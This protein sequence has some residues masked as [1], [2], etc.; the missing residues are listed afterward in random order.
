MKELADK[1]KINNPC[2]S[3]NRQLSFVKYSNKDSEHQIQEI[4]MCTQ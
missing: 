4:Y 2:K 1:Y 3:L